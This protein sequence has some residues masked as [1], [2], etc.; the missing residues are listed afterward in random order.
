MFLGYLGSRLEIALY[1]THDYVVV[2]HDPFLE[3][4][5]FLFPSFLPLFI[6]SLER[7]RCFL[8]IIEF[9]DTFT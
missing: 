7:N 4:C 5:L 8:L 1:R 6:S 2:I 9:I 3:V